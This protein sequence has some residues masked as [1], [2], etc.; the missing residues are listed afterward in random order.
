[1]LLNIDKPH[2]TSTLHQDACPQ[3]PSPFG[4]PHKPVNAVGRDGGWF[5][6]ASEE[7]AREIADKNFSRGDFVRCQKW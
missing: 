6:V 5:V 7:E 2:G 3:V 1:M 4:T